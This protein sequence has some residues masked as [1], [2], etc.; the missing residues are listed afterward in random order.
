M[1]KRSASAPGGARTREHR[2]DSVDDCPGVVE[3]L[4]DVVGLDEENLVFALVS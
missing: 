4:L 2:G 3:C 1:V